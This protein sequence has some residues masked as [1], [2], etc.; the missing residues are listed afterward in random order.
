MSKGDRMCVNAPV[1]GGAA[2]YMK[3]GMVRA[4]AAIKKAGLQDKIRMVM[5]IHDALE[6]YVHESIST[7]Q[8]I[9]L[10]Q[11][12]IS[13]PLKG[14]P[15]ILAEWHEGYKW[16]SVAEVLL[17]EN[18]KIIGYEMTVEPPT[19][20][21]L[22]WEEKELAA[23]LEPYNAWADAFYA[24]KEID[25]RPRAEKQSETQPG[26]TP[27]QTEPED[28]PDSPWSEEPGK[29]APAADP[30]DSAYLRLLEDQGEDL[31]AVPEWAA[32]PM[33][34]SELPR[35]EIRVTLDDMPDEEQFDRLMTFLAE[36]RGE[37]TTLKL[38]TP[39]GEITLPEHFSLSAKDAETISV[40]L[41]GARVKRDAEIELSL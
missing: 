38:L 37:R 16:G 8:V 14:M 7:Q 34:R 15:E 33:F 31:N 39:E 10:I 18:K 32:T 4:Q 36:H 25:G 13:F 29:E 35:D 27:N 23:V 28:I 1:Q 30:T 41:G 12:A 19:G 2:D 26:P 11:P 21:K 5:T 24:D 22:H 17:D 20:E 9:D 6:F 40:L 3:I